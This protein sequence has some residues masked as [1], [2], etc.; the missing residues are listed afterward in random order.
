MAP[1]RP[2]LTSIV[3]HQIWMHSRQWKGRKPSIAFVHMSEQILDV[4]PVSIPYT[5][6]IIL[7]CI[8]Y[9]F[10]LNMIYMYFIMFTTESGKRG[11]IIYC[12]QRNEIAYSSFLLSV[13]AELCYLYYIN[14]RWESYVN[15]LVSGIYD[16]HFKSTLSKITL[17]NNRLGIRCE[18]TPKR[19][20]HI[21]LMKGNFD[22][23]SSLSQC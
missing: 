5:E 22:S 11:L 20:P 16:N 19:M 17:L 2:C 18:I 6:F 13:W 21:P 9:S 8:L 3:A 7:G 1:W 4:M 12:G 23:N 14:I 10:A 15:S